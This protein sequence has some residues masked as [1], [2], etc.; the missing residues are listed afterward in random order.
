MFC[1]DKLLLKKKCRCSGNLWIAG[2]VN[3][4]KAKGP[5]NWCRL[6]IRHK[7]FYRLGKLFH[8]GSNNT[9]LVTS[10]NNGNRPTW[11]TGI[12]I[13]IH[14]SKWVS[15]FLK[16][17][18]SSLEGVLIIQQSD[19]SGR[20]SHNMTSCVNV[21]ICIDS[22]WSLCAESV[23]GG[24]DVVIK[25]QWTMTTGILIG[26][27]SG[28]ET[29]VNRSRLILVKGKPDLLQAKIKWN[30]VFFS[31]TRRWIMVGFFNKNWLFL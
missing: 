7:H 20:Y 9:T 18:H 2:V 1:L 25:G 10:P 8:T 11:A 6:F 30:W 3:Q 13:T 15:F 17:Y 23:N 22:F 31:L 27:I 16:V 5:R 24:T 26:G 19:G 14:K 21:I 4:R 28:G 29:P 12:V